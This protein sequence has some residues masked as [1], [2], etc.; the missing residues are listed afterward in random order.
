MTPCFDK[1]LP[2]GGEVD[3]DILDMVAMVGGLYRDKISVN[4]DLENTM[5]WKCSTRLVSRSG[6]SSFFRCLS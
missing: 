3:V 6:A 2:F 4:C 5:I 1:L